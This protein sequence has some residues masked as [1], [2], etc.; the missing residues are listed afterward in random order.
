MNSGALN[1]K[2]QNYVQIENMVFR[3]NRNTN[4]QQVY[5]GRDFSIT[6]FF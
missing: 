5:R 2:Q 4:W 1:E 6:R 3:R